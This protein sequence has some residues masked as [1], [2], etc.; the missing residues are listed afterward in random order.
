MASTAIKGTADG[1]VFCYRGAWKAVEG[2]PNMFLVSPTISSCEVAVSG[3]W[4]LG[5]I[6]LQ[7]GSVG[8]GRY[9]FLV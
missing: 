3:C 9:I 7:V 2:W 1:M 6:R 8:K 5:I 4:P